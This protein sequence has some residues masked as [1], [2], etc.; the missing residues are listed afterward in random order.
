MTFCSL[1]YTKIESF[2]VIQNECL[3]SFIYSLVG[4][5]LSVHSARHPSGYWEYGSEWNLTPS[6]WSLLSSWE[7]QAINKY[8]HK[9]EFQ[10]LVR[11]ME[12]QRGREWGAFGMVLQVFRV[13][14]WPQVLPS[15]PVL[16]TL[17]SCAFPGTEPRTLQGNQLY[18][19]TLSFSCSVVSDCDPM[20][21]STPDFPLL[22]YLL[23]FA[24]THIHS[25][26]DAIQPFP[27]LSSPSP[28]PSVFP[29]IGFF[30]WVSS[31]DQVAKVLEL[32]L[33]HQSF[34]WNFRVDFLWD[35]LVLS[36]CS[37]RDFQEMHNPKVQAGRGQ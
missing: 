37:P 18:S 1:N 20:D 9:T 3:H 8:T 36:P 25:V 32:Q 17:A 24:Q 35:W 5:I 11:A 23:E 14:L 31:L 26:G 34:Q 28:L 13:P 7:R 19:Q 15:R 27:L 4:H 29:M 33:Q 12:K 2:T 10:M 21:C 16:V 30:Q 6:L 22:C